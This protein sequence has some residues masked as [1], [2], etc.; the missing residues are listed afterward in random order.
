MLRNFASRTKVVALVG[1]AA[2][3]YVGRRYDLK[4]VFEK[5]TS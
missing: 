2:G 1:F 5:A 3:Y 4:I